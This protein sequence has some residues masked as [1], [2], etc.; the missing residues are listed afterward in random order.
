LAMALTPVACSR[1]TTDSSDQSEHARQKGGNGQLSDGNT[2]RVDSPQVESPAKVGLVFNDDRAFQGY[3]LLSP[4]RSRKTHFI[5]M[6]G[7]IV[8][9][10]DSECTPASCA[11]LL[12]KGNL[13]RP[14]SLGGEEKSFGGGPGAGGRVQEFTWDG[15]LVWDFKLFNDKQLPH[16]DI[17]PL[18]NG[19]VLMIVWDK[20][21]AKEAIAAGRQPDAPGDKHLPP[22][23][24]TA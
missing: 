13:L 23:P 12:D 10:W 21:T 17:A 14:G 6:H 11:Y 19:N 1:A 16:H 18:P 15:E 5:D 7:K 2:S 4:M 8:G 24:V 20:K 9:E 3:T 22:D